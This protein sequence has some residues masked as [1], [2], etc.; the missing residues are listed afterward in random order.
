MGLEIDNFS[1]TVNVC[2]DR[3]NFVM[4]LTTLDRLATLKNLEGD[5]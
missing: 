5:I 1:S 4:Y 3:N 2:R